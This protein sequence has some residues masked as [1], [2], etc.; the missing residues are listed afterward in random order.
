VK[1][2]LLGTGSAD[3]WPNAFCTCASCSAARRDGH[4]RGQT[5]A[6]IDDALL[7]DCGPEIPAAA[8]RHGA[9]FSRVRIMLFTHAHPDHVGPAALLFRHWAKSHDAGPGE[10][11]EVYAPQQ[12]LEQLKPWIA[13][14]DPVTLH[15]IE[16]NQTVVVA[17][18]SVRAIAAAHGDPGADGIGAALLFD[19]TGP[20][21]TRLLYATDTGPLPDATVAAVR[22]ARFDVVLLEETFGDHVSHDTDHLDLNTFPEQLRRLREVGALTEDCDVV[23]VHLSHHNPPTAQLQQRLSLWG[24][25]V[26]DDG[27]VIT[28]GNSTTSKSSPLRPHPHRTLVI[29]GARSGK[30]HHAESLLAA[31]SRVTY[32]ATAPDRPGDEEWTQR[33]AAHRARRPQHWTTIE[34]PDVA[35]ILTTAEPGDAVLIDCMTLWLT[36]VMDETDAW[37][38]DLSGVDKRIAEL[39]D[40]WRHTEA[41]VVA[42]TNEVGQGVVPATAS[43][44]LFRDTQGRLNAALAAASEDVTLMVAGQPWTMTS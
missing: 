34:S 32:C 20:S 21:G 8:A 16:A 39:L 42:V 12:V 41:Q 40:A 37:S 18:Y 31:S 43:G 23:A 9:D 11:L 35:G 15:L 28:A 44:R 24:A 2:Q 1:I 29:G 6:L 27:T 14:D 3:G 36:H 38:G 4:V 19:I 5:G 25:R 22:D 33:L 10:P 26:V 30:S 13:P 17:G 7:I